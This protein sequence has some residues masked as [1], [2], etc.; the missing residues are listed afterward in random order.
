MFKLKIIDFVCDSNNKFFKIIKTIKILEWFSCCNVLKI[1]T[2]IDI[3]VY[4]RIR[5]INFIIITSFIYY[6][7]KNEEIFVWAEEQKEIMNILKLI[8]TIAL[9]LKL[10]KYFF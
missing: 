5:V 2:L 4:Y 7:L 9:I 3:C 8:L 6:L 10:L 1:R